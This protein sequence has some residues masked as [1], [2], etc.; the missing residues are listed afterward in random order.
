MLSTLL[1]PVAQRS[2]ILP[3]IELTLSE[4]G[5]EVNKCLQ[6][7]VVSAKTEA[8]TKCWEDASFLLCV[9]VGFFYLTV[10][11]SMIVR[12]ANSFGK[13]NRMTEANEPEGCVLACNRGPVGSHVENWVDLNWNKITSQD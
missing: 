11:R 13:V 1:S 5:R 12:A 7:C 4:G 9:A 2:I 3:F 10:T 8:C 6:C